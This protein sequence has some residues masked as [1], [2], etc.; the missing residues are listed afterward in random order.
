MV[1]NLDLVLNVQGSNREIEKDFE[2]SSKISLTASNDFCN[3][4]RLLRAVMIH[5]AVNRLVD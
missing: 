1:V 4:V 3:I 5:R 2:K